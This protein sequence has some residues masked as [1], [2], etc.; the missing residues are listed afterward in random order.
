MDPAE[1]EFLAENEMVTIIPNF[2]YSKIFFIVDEVGPFRA[3]MPLRV[4][5]WLAINLKSRQKC[6]IIPPDWMD[7]EKLEELKEEEIRSD[8]FCKVP[9]EYYIVITQL[10]L[11]VAD[12]DIPRSE[13]L[14]TIIKDIWDKRQGEI[15]DFRRHVH[16]VR[17]ILPNA[18][19][20]LHRMQSVR[21]MALSQYAHASSSITP[22]SGY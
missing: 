7:L 1:V 4:P 8:Y 3:G 18:L 20:F 5:I 14:R 2:N 21:P 11:N 9:S 22:R 10:L 13:A 17:P 19:D 12:G 6:R 16:K 15:T